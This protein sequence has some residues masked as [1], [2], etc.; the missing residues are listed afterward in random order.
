MVIYEKPGSI[1]RLVVVLKSSGDKG[2][3]PLKQSAARRR[4]DPNKNKL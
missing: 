3:A 1:R 4:D 2:K